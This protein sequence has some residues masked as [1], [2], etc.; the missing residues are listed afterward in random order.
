[1]LRYSDREIKEHFDKYPDD[2]ALVKLISE[3][4]F[5]CEERADGA[6]LE[7]YVVLV[8]RDGESSFEIEDARI[9]SLG[10]EEGAWL[11][12]RQ[13]DVLRKK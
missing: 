5:G 7:C 2:Y 12:E 9:A 13:T 6:P 10:T 4:D 3:A 11:T 1:M 8:T